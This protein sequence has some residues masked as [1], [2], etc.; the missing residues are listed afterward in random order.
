MIVSR[1]P[2]LLI[3]LFAFLGPLGTLVTPRFLPGPFRFY[4]VLLSAFLFFWTKMKRETFRTALFFFPFLAYVLIS[5][6]FC[7]NKPSIELDPSFFSKACLFLSHCFFVIGAVSYLQNVPSNDAFQKLIR[8]YLFG[9][10]LSLLVGYALFFG[11]YLQHL[12]LDTLD[13]FTVLT[14]F[15]YGLLR[16]SPG[17]YANEY[18][19]VSSFVCSI[20]LL[21]LA[22]QKKGK[23]PLFLFFLFSFTALLLTT[24]RAAYLCFLFALVYL[25]FISKKLR[26][27]LSLFFG[28]CLMGFLFFQKGIFSSIWNGIVILCTKVGTFKER[29]GHWQWGI[30]AFEDHLFF[31]EGFGF[32]SH[33]HNV[34]LEL[35]FEL[36]IVGCLLLIGATLLSF[37]NRRKAIQ[38]LFFEKNLQSRVVVL[39]LMHVFWFALS[40]HNLNHHLTWMVLLLM[41][42]YLKKPDTLLRSAS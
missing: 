39:G 15:G 33:I 41:A 8:L 12:T 14:Q 7:F 10:G 13:R 26:M 38:S 34:F 31:G 2:L 3:Y 17:S 37:L 20:L 19:I 25:G 1:F 18:G 35:F 23:I 29:L 40:N 9:Y 16:F 5:G 27:A 4:Y 32:Y 11:F 36:G 6:F 21:L 24:T 22:E 42:D 30:N 28:G